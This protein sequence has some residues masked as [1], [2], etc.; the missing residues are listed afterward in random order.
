MDQ[1]TKKDWKDAGIKFVWA[2]VFA[3]IIIG[4]GLTLNWALPIVCPLLTGTAGWITTKSDKKTKLAAAARW[5][6][7]GFLA[8]VGFM[9]CF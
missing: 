4:T 7:V 3:L 5:A 9:L 6:L 1:D 8:G 2:A